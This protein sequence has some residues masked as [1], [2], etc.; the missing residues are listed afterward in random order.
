MIVHKLFSSKIICKR[1]SIVMMLEE[2]VGAL[3]SLGSSLIAQTPPLSRQCRPR[4][5]WLIFQDSR[6]D[7]ESYE[8]LIHRE[9]EE[10]MTQKI[11]YYETIDIPVQN[12]GTRARPSICE[13]FRRSVH[14]N[15]GLR[16]AV[17]LLGL[18]AIGLVY[19]DLK[20]NNSCI[21]WKHFNHST[22]AGVKRLYTN[23]TNGTNTPVH[24]WYQSFFDF[25]SVRR[26][27]GA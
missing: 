17:V 24:Q 22:Q 15:I 6:E 10:E 25:P 20:T 23:G 9:Y 4:Y 19:L 13:S 8:G 1:H 5:D 26:C 11:P 12:T 21:E 16:L 27:C 2:L 18:V 14:V 7:E 3:L